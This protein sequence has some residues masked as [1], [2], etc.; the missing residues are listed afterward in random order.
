MQ[1]KKMKQKEKSQIK[2][3]VKIKKIEKD[4]MSLPQN[5]PFQRLMM[6]ISS[7]PKKIA[8]NNLLKVLFHIQ[9]YKY[10]APFKIREQVS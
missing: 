1:T 6:K 10:Q 7:R 9:L 2:L 5:Y 4:L 3:K 8:D